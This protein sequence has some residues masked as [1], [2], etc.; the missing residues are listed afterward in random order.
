MKKVYADKKIG[1]TQGPFESPG[2]FNINLD[3]GPDQDLDGTTVY[4]E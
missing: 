3:C 1:L 2:N 4:D